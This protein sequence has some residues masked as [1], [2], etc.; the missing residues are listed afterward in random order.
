M[1]S[2]GPRHDTQPAGVERADEEVR[3]D[4]PLQL[5]AELKPVVVRRP[6]CVNEFTQIRARD[7]VY[8]PAQVAARIYAELRSSGL[9]TI[10]ERWIYFISC[11]KACV[12]DLRMGRGRLANDNPASTFS[13]QQSFRRRAKVSVNVGVLWERLYLAFARSLGLRRRQRR[14]VRVDRVDKV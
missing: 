14:F 6:F 8:T 9:R 7:G 12:I 13:G 3:H 10:L 5:L 4:A 1:Y 2:L 11:V